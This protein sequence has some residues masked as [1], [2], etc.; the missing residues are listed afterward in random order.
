ME[1]REHDGKRGHKSDPRRPQKATRGG[2]DRLELE[3][4]E[5]R[6]IS[7]HVVPWSE[8]NDG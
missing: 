2:G 6:M 4:Y 3:G 8:G 1:S 5:G 7:A